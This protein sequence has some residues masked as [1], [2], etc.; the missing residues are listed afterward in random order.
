WNT[1]I[2]SLLIL[3][4]FPLLAAALIALFVD[5]QF[6]AHVFDPGTGGVMLWQHLFWFFGHPEVYVLAL[7]FFGIVSEIFPV[8]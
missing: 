8:F 2:A 1:F 3:L 5:R 7:P 6:G 4:I